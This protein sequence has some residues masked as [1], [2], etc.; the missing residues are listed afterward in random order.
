MSVYRLDRPMLLPFSGFH[1][2]VLR[3]RESLPKLIGCVEETLFST[4]L[5][6]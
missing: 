1:T 5:C 2:T 3:L 6:S 4:L